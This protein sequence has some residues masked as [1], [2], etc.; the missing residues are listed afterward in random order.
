MFFEALLLLV[1][2]LLVNDWALR[3]LRLLLLVHDWV[4]QL[5]VGVTC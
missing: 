2:V 5:H 3:L 4:W 1:L